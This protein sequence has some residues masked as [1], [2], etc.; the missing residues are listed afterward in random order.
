MD[1]FHDWAPNTIGTLVNGAADAF[2]PFVSFDFKHQNPPSPLM[3]AQAEPE[4][5]G[6]AGLETTERFVHL[7]L[8]RLLWLRPT[9]NRFPA[10]GCTCIGAMSI[11]RVR[12]VWLRFSR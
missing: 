9:R 3:L 11:S 10:E 8:R 5:L 12:A 7:T 1:L 2:I 6:H 4:N